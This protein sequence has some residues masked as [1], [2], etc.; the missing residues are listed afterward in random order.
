MIMQLSYPMAVAI[1]ISREIIEKYIHFTF[2]FLPGHYHRINTRTISRHYLGKY[3]YSSLLLILKA[4][5][6]L[7]IHTYS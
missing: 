2:P 5:K 6:G 3:N 1:A 4:A 7:C